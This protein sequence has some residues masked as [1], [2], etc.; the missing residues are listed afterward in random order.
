M[1]DAAR[2]AGDAALE[3]LVRSLREAGAE[4]ARIAF[5][6]GSGLGGLAERLAGVRRISFDSLEGMPLSRV[7]GHPGEILLGELA[8]V[9]ALVQVGRVHL[10]EGSSAREVTRA[11]R[12]YAALGCRKLVLTNAAG[13]LREEWLPGTLMRIDDHVNMQGATPLALDEMGLGSPYDRGLG[14][15][16]EHGAREAKITLASGVYAALPGPSYETPA[17]IRM[18]RR[19]GA[20][21]VDMPTA[22]EALAAHAAGARVAAVSVITNAAA[23][24]AP[25]RLA[26]A[27]VL[28]AARAASTKLCGLLESAASHL[29]GA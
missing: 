28:E 7:P 16:L 5:V 19:L 26:H 18:L 6:F 25:R 24:I 22:A 1:S 14:L 10:Y 13:G 8:G 15:A 12:A 17:E 9:P 27:D 29:D 2:T 21:A 11:V 23:G 20:D 4:G 3:A